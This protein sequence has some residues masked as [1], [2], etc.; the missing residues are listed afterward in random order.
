MI[1]CFVDRHY[2][3]SSSSPSLALQRAL[4]KIQRF[5]LYINYRHYM[6]FISFSRNHSCLQLPF[7][8]ENNL[9]FTITVHLQRV[10]NILLHGKGR[11]ASE[12]LQQPSGRERSAVATAC[13][14]CL[15]LL[16]Q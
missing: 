7:K 1:V 5:E 15:F 12:I 8:K 2:V 14:L 4:S 3:R 16:V 6:H 10:Q 11:C 13:Y 9:F